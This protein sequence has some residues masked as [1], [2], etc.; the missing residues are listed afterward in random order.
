MKEGRQVLVIVRSSLLHAMAQAANLETKLV[1]HAYR[2]NGEA[3]CMDIDQ[4]FRISIA[5]AERSIFVR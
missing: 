2:C 3:C 4:L 5:S 1:A